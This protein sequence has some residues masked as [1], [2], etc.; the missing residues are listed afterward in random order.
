V[1]QSAILSASVNAAENNSA[2][3]YFPVARIDGQSCTLVTLDSTHWRT[4]TEFSSV[5]S[6]HWQVTLKA[7]NRQLANQYQQEITG[8]QNHISALE[9]ELSQPSLSGAQKAEI[10]QQINEDQAA[11]TQFQEDF[12]GSMKILETDTL[13][14]FV[15]PAPSP[16]PS[17]THSLALPF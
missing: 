1:G 3:E 15:S 12:S 5:G 14:V 6:H 4:T 2:L 11:L 10:Q 7:I 9:K 16:S 13:S 17:P 8:Y